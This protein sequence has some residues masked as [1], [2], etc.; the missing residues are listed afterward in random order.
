MTD[1]LVDKSLSQLLKAFASSDPTPGGGSASALAGAVGSSLLLMVASLPKTRHGS[2]EDR[3][4]LSDAREALSPAAR[5]LA[6]LVDRDTEAYDRVVAAYRLPKGADAEKAS[7]REAIQDAMRGAIDTPLAML[8]AVHT[9]ARAAVAVARHGSP[10]AASDV[11]VAAA[12]LDAA[13]G[14]AY[15]NVAINLGGFEDASQG[16]GLAR[17]ARTLR[18]AVGAETAT[19]RAAVAVD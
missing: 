13:A 14:G 9:A 5:E 11:I 6:S 19:A 1:K 16:S 8:R 12:L 2:L 3:S 17:E 10:S 15:A 4:A 18:E 7:R